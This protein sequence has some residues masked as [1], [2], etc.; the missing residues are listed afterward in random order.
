MSID[1]DTLRPDDGHDDEDIHAGLPWNHVARL[2]GRPGLVWYSRVRKVP[3]AGLTVGD[4][5]DS[6]DHRGAR[7]ICDI[8][9]GSARPGLFSR[10]M[11]T[12]GRRRP[13]E[14]LRTA[15]FSCGDT[16]TVHRGV[17]YDVVDPHSQVTPDG[18]P[19]ATGWPEPWAAR[20]VG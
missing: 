6:L 14:A 2:D 8:R 3:G 17:E 15:V 7:M 13:D 11:R 4:W 9:D 19:V 10:L 1:P 20:P 12:L 16:E 18:T 5:L